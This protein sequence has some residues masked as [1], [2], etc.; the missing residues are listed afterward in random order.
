MCACVLDMVSWCDLSRAV[1]G[2]LHTCKA[3]DLLDLLCSFHSQ[4]LVRRSHQLLFAFAG[5]VSI[6]P[7]N[8][9]GV[10]SSL[11]PFLEMDL[12]Y[13]KLFMLRVHVV[14][15]MDIM[16]AL[17]CE[18]GATHVLWNDYGKLSCLFKRTETCKEHNS[19]HSRPTK[20][21]Q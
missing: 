13:E 15:R 10:F 14:E 4:D 20:A 2:N 19:S 5:P 11:S 9:R 12:S 1:F 7:T 16:S 18:H 17:C 21:S 6:C 8:E 3:M